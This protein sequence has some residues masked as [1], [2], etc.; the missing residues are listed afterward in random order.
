VTDP[1]DDFE[2]LM[3]QGGVVKLGDDRSVRQ[4]R[5]AVVRQQEVHHESGQAEFEA[6]MAALDSVPKKDSW[7]PPTADVSDRIQRLDLPRRAAIH[8]DGRLDLHGLTQEEAIKKLARFV[9]GAVVS[10]IR[11]ILVVTGKGLNSPDGVS[12]LRPVVEGW[13]QTDGAR[14]VAA[15]GEAPRQYGGR[16]ALVI[17]LR[18]S[19]KR[20][21]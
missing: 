8:F 16:G 1:D 9:G 3:E 4:R 14:L 21:K 20:D 17:D 18:L 7:E 6:A 13:I 5:Q 2:R 19:T 11:R 12:V 15:F 10:G